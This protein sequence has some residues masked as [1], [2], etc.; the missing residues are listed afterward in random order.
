MDEKVLSLKAQR[1]QL[2]AKQD[3]WEATWSTMHNGRA[4]TDADRQRSHEYR[5]LSRLLSD[6]DE[7]VLALE[8]GTAGSVPPPQHSQV[9]ERRAERGRI[10]ARMR[11]WEKEFERKFGRRPTEAET[12]ASDEMAHF[13]SQLSETTADGCTSLDATA[14][15]YRGDGPQTSPPSSILTG[16]DN[17][18]AVAGTSSS[19]SL[20]DSGW[21][22]GNDYHELLRE[23]VESHAAINGFEGVSPND[24]HAAAQSFAAWDLDRDGVLSK[25]E[26]L[27]VLASLAEDDGGLDVNTLERLFQIMDADRNGFIDF[28][29]YLAV[30]Q[31]LWISA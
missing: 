3:S 6:I 11:R 7:Y 14:A 27:G 21:S 1:A 2:E 20:G 4:A 23:R 22:H 29:E 12:E 30:R 19:S 16:G 18:S 8:R 13:R 15:G 25:E 17:K 9:A 24:V 10:K 31:R 28:N 5:E 26:A